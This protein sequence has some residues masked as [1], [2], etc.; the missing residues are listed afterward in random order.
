LPIHKAGLRTALRGKKS[1]SI[2]C[3]LLRYGLRHQLAALRW[4]DYI[5]IANNDLTLI[6]KKSYHSSVVFD[7]VVRLGM[8]QVHI[9]VLEETGCNGIVSVLEVLLL[10]ITSKDSPAKQTCAILAR[11]LVVVLFQFADKRLELRT[12]DMHVADRGVWVF[13]G[14]ALKP[15]V[16][17][18]LLI[19]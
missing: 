15:V 11:I 9:F 2:S 3:C 7:L 1:S 13:N 17:S 8:L 19:T 12:L 18:H 16:I 4:L 10:L 6:V 14:R 5:G